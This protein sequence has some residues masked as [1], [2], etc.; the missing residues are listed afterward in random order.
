MAA[1]KGLGAEK[2]NYSLSIPIRCIQWLA[3][4]KL[5]DIYRTFNIDHPA[6]FRGTAFGQ[7]IVALKEQGVVILSLRYSIGIKNCDL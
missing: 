6:D 4:E 1:E 2:D 7:D 5:E 3:L